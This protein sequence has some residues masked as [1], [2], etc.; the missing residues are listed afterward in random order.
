MKCDVRSQLRATLKAI[1]KEKKQIVVSGI[2]NKRE[3]CHDKWMPTQWQLLRERRRISSIGHY[4][5]QTN[6]DINQ[7]PPLS[8]PTRLRLCVT[9]ILLAFSGQSPTHHLFSWRQKRQT[10]RLDRMWRSERQRS[11]WP[12]LWIIIIIATPAAA[13]AAAPDQSIMMKTHSSSK[14]HLGGWTRACSSSS[15]NN[16]HRPSASLPFQQIKHTNNHGRPM[17]SFLLLRHLEKPPALARRVRMTVDS[18]ADFSTS[19]SFL[20]NDGH[21]SA[22]ILGASYKHTGPNILFSSTRWWSLSTNDAQLFWLLSQFSSRVGEVRSSDTNSQSN[23]YQLE[24]MF[25]KTRK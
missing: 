19:P 10:T 25:Q 23:D 6:S 15:S 20:S 18:L 1:E 12:S 7:H 13:A 16:N 14:S 21:I 24:S 8:P 9:H 17:T 4:T 22:N 11:P 5:Q 2:R 3:A